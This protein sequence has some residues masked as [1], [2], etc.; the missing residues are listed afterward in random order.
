MNAL[1]LVRERLKCLWLDHTSYI[2]TTFGIDAIEGFVGP[3]N[4]SEFHALTALHIIPNY[5]V[6]VSQGEWA[7]E[8]DYTTW[9]VNAP[10]PMYKRLPDSLEVLHIMAPE[11]QGEVE[12]V[13][14]GVRNIIPVPKVRSHLPHLHEIRLEAPSKAKGDASALGIPALQQ[15]ANYAGIRL[16]KLECSERYEEAWI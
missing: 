3:V 11:N 1:N 9:V 7:V 16:R 14:Q 10:I 8:E 5:L 13:A 2:D 6:G 12:L 15:D 4:L